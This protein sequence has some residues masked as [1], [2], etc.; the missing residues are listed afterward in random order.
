MPETNIF[1][2]ACMGHH[3]RILC[4]W[5]PPIFASSEN[6]QRI[7]FVVFIQKMLT[8]PLLLKTRAISS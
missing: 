3:R 8:V 2:V 6:S 1:R 7:L 4:C 5:F